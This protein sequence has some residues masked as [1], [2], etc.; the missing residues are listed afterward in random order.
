[1]TEY[2]STGTAFDDLSA[3]V[4]DLLDRVP[5]RSQ[6]LFYAAAADAL[7]DDAAV[8]PVAEALAAAH[9]FSIHGDAPVSTDNLLD[10]I[11]A[12]PDDT[13]EGGIIIHDGLICIDIA[14]R[15]IRGDFNARDGMWYVL[16]PRLQAVSERLS[17]ASQ[18]SA[19]S[20]RHTV[21]QSLWAKRSWSGW[22]APSKKFST[23]YRRNPRPMRT[24]QS[25][26]V[27]C[28]TR[29]RNIDRRFRLPLLL[30]RSDS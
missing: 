26:G 2:A 30:S 16:E 11:A 6:V 21:S 27:C 12:A 19:A 10:A 13:S 24:Q 4:G 25:Y 15:I 7:L 9:R 23:A 20:A 18:M 29:A 8:G 22:C 17:S 5:R 1:V 28:A 14:L 3:R